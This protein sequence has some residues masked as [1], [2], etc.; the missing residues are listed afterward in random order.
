VRRR[1]E[2]LRDGADRGEGLRPSFRQAAGGAAA[3]P[4]ATIGALLAPFLLL[5][6]VAEVDRSRVR[7]PASRVR[8]HVTRGAACVVIA[9][10]A[11]E[12]RWGS[13]V[14]RFSDGSEASRRLGGPTDI[15]LAALRVVS[16]D[17]ERPFVIKAEAG[18]RYGLVDDVLEQLRKAGVRDLTLLTRPPA[19]G[20][21]P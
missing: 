16:E 21:G 8:P 14:Y 3:V 17:P 9:R 5:T 10:E 11:G 18:I 19:I 6:L 1:R 7:L 4:L 2:L 15:F 13:L 12:E 20:S